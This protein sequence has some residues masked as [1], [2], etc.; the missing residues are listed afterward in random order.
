MI[1]AQG[2]PAEELL[3]RI[4]ELRGADQPTTGGRAWQ[5]S[6]DSA[7]PEVKRLAGEAFTRWSR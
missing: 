1:P 2:A 5:Y 7:R 4:E 3:G 6:Y